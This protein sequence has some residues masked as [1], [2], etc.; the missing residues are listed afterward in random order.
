MAIN[1]RSVA[2][3]VWS[4]IAVG[5]VAAVVAY[6]TVFAH[7]GADALVLLPSSVTAVAVMDLNPG[8][9]Q[10]GAYKRI[11][12]A[13][14]R[15][16]L[17]KKFDSMFFDITNTGNEKAV[18]FRPYLQRGAA[19]AT[20]PGNPNPHFVML[21]PITDSGAVSKLLKENGKAEATNGVA[22]YLLPATVTTGTVSPNA[23]FAVIA[24]RL[25]VA[26]SATSLGDV[27][28]T[29]R[30]ELPRLIDQRDFMAAR[31]KIPADANFFSVISPA[32]TKEITKRDSLVEWGTFAMTL[33][34]Q[35][36]EVVANGK[37]VADLL[38]QR[39]KNG[40]RPSLRA[41]LLKSLP[42]NP[43]AIVAAA[44][45]GDDLKSG[46]DELN[47][48]SAQEY[49]KNLTDMEKQ[50]D[51]SVERD[52]MP[53]LEGTAVAALYPAAG[54]EGLNLVLLIDSDNGA[55]PAPVLQKLVDQLT[56]GKPFG[57]QPADA[58][59]TPPVPVAEKET[60]GEWTITKPTAK[61]QAETDK[62]MAESGKSSG[63]PKFLTN[64]TLVMATK[65]DAVLI[66][67]NRELLDRCI[68]SYDAR[69]TTEQSNSPLAG[70]ASRRDPRDQFLVAV[71]VAAVS[72][73]IRRGYD[74][75]ALESDARK[76]Y[77]NTMDAL[78]KLKEP[79]MYSGY[80]S[81]DGEMSVKMLIP[82]DWDLLI[83]SI[84]KATKAQLTPPKP[85]TL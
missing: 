76:T 38:P 17:G 70:I 83:D 8:P 51:L 37:A 44:G 39:L 15:N 34:D 64:K 30:G 74:G 20:L 23:C 47:M 59:G 43:Y 82:M 31:A 50:L 48:S 80:V 42:E 33:R 22:Y 35:G 25:V 10:A 71:S 60:D 7:P 45:L 66:A 36:I 46:L 18:L 53:A 32:L 6:K 73:T 13:L 11:N 21:L 27:M 19:I 63:M 69:A 4:L 65:G 54:G 72:E 67:T 14:D 9:S 62:S 49:K 29:S 75:A 55:K 1:G 26:D 58:S 68:K 40:S 3:G 52:L 84:G 28:K 85:V 79:M 57:Q 24:D 56:S 2:I 81:K 61:A 12:D 77:N 5:T 78:A 16:E 41:D